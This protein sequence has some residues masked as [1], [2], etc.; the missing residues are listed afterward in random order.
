MSEVLTGKKGKS[1]TLNLF[2]L[3]KYLPMVCL[4]T[5][6]KR[7]I[8]VEVTSLMYKCQKFIFPRL[9]YLIM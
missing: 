1:Y 5:K 3:N 8:L 9:L 6:I 4:L 2:F 7:V